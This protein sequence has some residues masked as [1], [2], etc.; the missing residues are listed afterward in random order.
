MGWLQLVVGL[1]VMGAFL[2]SWS[3]M[4]DILKSWTEKEKNDPQQKRNMFLLINE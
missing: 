4:P 3:K 1:S 2:W